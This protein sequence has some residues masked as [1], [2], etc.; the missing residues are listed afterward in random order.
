MVIQIEH[1]I[2]TIVV[3]DNHFSENKYA[4]KLEFVLSTKIILPK[5]TKHKRWKRRKKKNLG[6]KGKIKIVVKNKSN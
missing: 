1:Q 5:F 2:Y 6:S 3:L 4:E